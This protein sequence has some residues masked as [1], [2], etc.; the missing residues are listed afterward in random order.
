M[1]HRNGDKPTTD[2]GLEVI[3]LN[4]ALGYEPDVEGG[5]AH[6]HGD[7][8]ADARAFRQLLCSSDACN[9]T[10]VDRLQ[11]V[12]RV[13][14]CHSAGIMYDEHRLLIAGL[15][16]VRGQLVE[17]VEHRLVKEG[18]DDR[19]VRPDVFALPARDL[20]AERSGDRP[21]LV[22]RIV[23]EDDLEDLLFV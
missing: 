21:E 5:A 3:V 12:S 22:R 13:R 18:V 6:V 7:D 1:D 8:V 4:S 14:L 11:G 16:E 15:A 10:R 9:R 2:R 23:I 19:R 20:A 17:R